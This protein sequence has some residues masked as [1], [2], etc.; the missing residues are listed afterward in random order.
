MPRKHKE[1]SEHPAKSPATHEHE[2]GGTADSV[3]NLGHRVAHSDLTKNP[4]S[5][6]PP[7]EGPNSEVAKS[8]RRDSNVQGQYGRVG[9]L[10]SGIASEE[11]LHK[12]GSYSEK[13][14]YGRDPA[15]QNRYPKNTDK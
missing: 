14:S 11:N 15:Y 5:H 12:W 4:T 13:N 3:M 6:L 1:L 9:K 8:F 2:S 7:Y 10:D